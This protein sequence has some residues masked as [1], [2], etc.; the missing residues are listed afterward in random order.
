MIEELLT[1][2]E[3]ADRRLIEVMIASDPSDRSK[4]LFSHILNAQH[5][6]ARRILGRKPLYAV[7]QIHP[8]EDFMAISTANVMELRRCHEEVP[9]DQTVRYITSLGEEYENAAGD[10]LFHVI[11]HSTYHRGQI[12]T[13][14]RQGGVVPPVTD[15]IILKRLGL[16]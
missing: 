4:Y 12:A 1:Y 5:I 16:L 11:N 10:I 13:D 6:W 8:V 15:F 2:T 14:L 7:D 9:A 3:V